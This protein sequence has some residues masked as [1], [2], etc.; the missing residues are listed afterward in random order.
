LGWA[1]D[2]SKRTENRRWLAECARLSAL[3]VAT[4]AKS[5]SQPNNNAS[6]TLII[7]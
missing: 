3:S 2:I 1:A 6:R 4:E 5:C 7:V